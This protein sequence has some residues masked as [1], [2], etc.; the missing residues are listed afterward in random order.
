MAAASAS[1]A[2][3]ASD[4]THPAVKLSPAPTMSTGPSTRTAGTSL[5]PRA[6]LARTPRSPS[7]S[8]KA[9]PLR[10]SSLVARAETAFAAAEVALEAGDLGEYQKQIDLAAGYVAEAN[11]IIAEAAAAITADSA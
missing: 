1:M 7:V 5:W 10:S 6:S 4:R 9:W 3:A 11:R 2:P 8:S